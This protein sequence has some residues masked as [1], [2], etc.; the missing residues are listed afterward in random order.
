M[1]SGQTYSGFS[2]TA[3]DLLQW[4]SFIKFISATLAT[5]EA[6]VEE[7]TGYKWLA[8]SD[9]KFMFSFMSWAYE[10]ILKETGFGKWFF[11]GLGCVADS[12]TATGTVTDYAWKPCE[13]AYAQ[14]TK[15]FL[16]GFAVAFW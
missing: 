12:D 1:S 5:T 15:A 13:L 11:F 14:Y 6:Q 2:Y 4:Q 3:T 8:L 7:L 9:G 16:V 10:L